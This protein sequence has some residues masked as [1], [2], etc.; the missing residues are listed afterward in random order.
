MRITTNTLCSLVAALLLLAGGTQ[1]HAADPPSF[2][3]VGDDVNGSWCPESTGAET[4]DI[5]FADGVFASFSRIFTLATL[6]INDTFGIFLFDGTFWILIFDFDG[7]V[8]VS[9]SDSGVRMEFTVLG[10]G[11]GDPDADADADGVPDAEDNCPETPNEDQANSDTD[12]H[13]DACD[14]CPLTDNEDQFNSDLDSFGDECDNC[15]ARDNEDQADSDGDGRG[16]L[17][18]DCPSDLSPTIIIGG[19]DTGV[20]NH[21]FGDGCTFSDLIADCAELAANHGEYVRC[22]A[23]LATSWKKAG[24]ISGNQRGTI[25]SSAAQADIP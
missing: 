11:S 7:S 20:L 6:F 17:C 12:S 9:W 15:P 18:D 21:L 25:V 22:V 10:V 2:E 19:L 1:V 14:N 16:D 13:G 4:F 8:P 5:E 24:L 23:H 3:D